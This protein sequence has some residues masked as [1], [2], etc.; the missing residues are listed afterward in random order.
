MRDEPILSLPVG[1]IQKAW[2]WCRRKPALATFGIS[3]V[4]LLL[5]L[6]VGGPIA[7]SKQ[8]ALA[9][10]NRRLLYASD[11]KVAHQAWDLGS[12]AR[13]VEL[14]E[15]NRPQPG[16]TD[17]REFTWY[18][19]RGLCEPYLRTPTLSHGL[20]IFMLAASH[21]RR[22]LAASGSGAWV[23][24]WDLADPAVIRR[25]DNGGPY[26]RPTAISPDNRL[27]VCISG[28]LLGPY[29]FNVWDLQNSVRLY[30]KEKALGMTV[31]FSPDG[32]LLAAGQGT[33][34]VLVD[35]R[36]WREVRTN[37]GHEGKVWEVRFAPDGRRLASCAE[38]RTI[39]L[40]D[41]H[42]GQSLRTFEGHDDIVYGLGF[43][44]DGQRLVSAS[45]DH[46]VRLWDMNSGKELDRYSHA[47]PVMGVDFS[48][49]GVRVASG[50]HDGLVKV[51]NLANKQIRTLRGHSQRIG[52]V[53]FV[54]GGSK[55]VSGSADGTLKLWDLKEEPPQ[56][57][58]E[59]KGT[60]RSWS[61]VERAPLAFT[62]DGSQVLT[63]A[64]NR[65]AILMWQAASGAFQRRV[66]LG[67]RPTSLLAGRSG[68]LPA[69][70]HVRRRLRGPGQRGGGK[71]PDRV[72]EHHRGPADPR[73]SRSDSPLLLPGRNVVG[74]WGDRGADV[75]G[76]QPGR[77]PK[78]DQAARCESRPGGCGRF[79]P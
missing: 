72:V 35:V 74:H 63:I 38:D 79:L 55:L 68:C 14:L 62:P 6:A 34:V 41:V 70:R 37:R 46:S 20:A 8:R 5:V 13:A 22:W 54:L 59:G 67:P 61:G 39:R 12:M 10:R 3:A 64:S 50:S 42:T 33:D 24:A 65:A 28:P 56:N 45:A 53:R 48:P 30:R 32:A 16:Q 76:D 25:M 57:E 27:L 9:E 26:A 71:E 36:D 18:Y 77:R 4:G 11:L 21:D 69:R 29:D 60:T 31:D 73:V 58:L 51:W 75:A 47:G 66:E 23:T 49:D 52:G 7:A 15:R 78:L 19:L 17:L 40:W 1:R 2:R 43:A 44:P